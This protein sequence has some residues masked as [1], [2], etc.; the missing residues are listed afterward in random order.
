[1]EESAKKTI[2]ACNRATTANLGSLQGVIDAAFRHYLSNLQCCIPV[3]VE[4]Y[5]RDSRVVTVKPLVKRL[6]E[7]GEYV[8]RP[9]FDCMAMQFGANGF[10]VDFPITEG[11]CGWVIAADVATENAIDNHVPSNPSSD[12][13]HSYP[14]GFFIPDCFG[15]LRDKAVRNGIKEGET[16]QEGTKEKQTYAGENNRLT[17]ATSDG[18]QRISIGRQDIQVIGD[19]VSITSNGL[20]SVVSNGSVQVKSTKDL[21]LEAGAAG[22][23]KLYGNE[24]ELSG[25]R[26]R[27]NTQLFEC[28]GG[29]GFSKGG[30]T[31]IITGTM[32]VKV[33][34]GVVVGISS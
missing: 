32:V 2:E 26:C 4:L 17:I 14:H 8:E 18:A 34:K 21:S 6:T 29:G 28:A 16:Y 13:T 30:Y 10:V 22:K 9:H 24:V 12:T 27:I 3:R 7:G 33:E 23:L 15:A 5:R 1:M 25:G 31:G 19:D 20:C 11:D